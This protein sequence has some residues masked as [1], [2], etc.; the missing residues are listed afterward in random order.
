MN[1]LLMIAMTAFLQAPSLCAWSQPVETG[2]LPPTINESS[3][4]AVSRRIADRTYRINDS[5]DTGRFFALD[6]KGGNLRIVN[7]AGFQPRDVED[8]AVGPCATGDCIFIGDIGDNA[9]MRRN[10]E[11]VVVEE[12]AEFPESVQAKE[13]VRVQ[14][15]D[16]PRDAESMAVHP[17]GTIY[18]LTK[19]AAGSE[20]YRLRRNQ[21]QGASDEVQTLERL[22][23]VDLAKLLPVSTA[24]DRLATSMDISPDGKRVLIL[25]YRNAVELAI[26][27]SATIPEPS[28]WQPGLHYKQV[29]LVTLE[30]QEAIAYL[31]NGR[32]FLYDTEKAPNAKAARIMQATCSN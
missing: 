22:V 12:R 1:L 17:D 10:I 16:R 6:L 19:D 9:R 25:T 11:I 7:V 31:P 24:L 27:L 15:P 3:G 13:R 21:W 32:G 14:Y 4:L 26:D 18:I 29:D 8:V 23:A 5:G 28:S 20:I 2:T 30:Q